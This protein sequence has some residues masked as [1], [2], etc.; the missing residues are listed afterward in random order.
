M[1]LGRLSRVVVV[2]AMAAAGVVAVQSPTGAVPVT[3]CG[4]ALSEPGSYE[5]TG[6]LSCPGAGAAI[7]ITGPGVHLDL[8]G[9][10]LTGDLTEDGRGVHAVSATGFS[11]ANGNVRNFYRGINVTASSD[12]T[13]TGIHVEGPWDVD[14]GVGSFYGIYVSSS[15]DIVVEDNSVDG[16]AFGIQLTAQTFVPLQRIAVRDNEVV[17]AAFIGIEVSGG[18]EPNPQ[19]DIAIENNSFIG[20]GDYNVHLGSYAQGNRIAGNLLEG[21]GSSG[22]Q[23]AS[24]EVRDN[25]VEGNRIVGNTENGIRVTSA[26]EGSNTFRANVVLDNGVDINDQSLGATCGLQVYE[27]NV[28]E[29]DSEG[30]G[31]TAGCIRGL[32]IAPLAVTTSNLPAATV[33]VPYAATI[34]AS[35]G[36]TPYSWSVTAGAL[37][38]GLSLAP[39][40]AISGTPTAAGSAVF[41]AT[42]TDDYVPPRTASKSFVVSVVS[43]GT[44]PPPPPLCGGKP[45]TVVGT[46]K[47]EQLI[48][49]PGP[50][51]VVAGRG[52]DV[53]DGRGGDDVVC[54]GPGRDVVKG[55]AGDDVLD[56]GKGRD[57]V[58]G[59]AGVDLLRGR[60]GGDTLRGGAAADDLRG[61]RQ[62]DLCAG[63]AGQDASSGCET[64]KGLP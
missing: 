39:S 9:H 37:P 25:V 14:A 46:A 50:D 43:V 11:I 44:V 51:V 6:D 20:S 59:G 61:G 58:L 13:V 17:G 15:T 64:L 22:L 12:G 38:A 62:L 30:D 28:F 5:L 32:A 33:G 52:S 56:G 7:T 1:G 18:S 26:M 53:V 54:A 55:R 3:S 47:G 40:G 57:R 8:G 35:G 60:F 27:D 23:I 41:T 4:T 63:G 36:L 21:A 34:T 19:T 31:P 45:A 42:V 29:T 48:G 2:A 24:T 10:T 16:T 49:T